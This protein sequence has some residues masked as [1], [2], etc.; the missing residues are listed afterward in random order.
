MS[1]AKIR[2]NPI[3]F[4]PQKPILSLQHHHIFRKVAQSILLL[5]T[6][7]GDRL[8]LLNGQSVKVFLLLLSHAHRFNGRRQAD[9]DG[10]KILF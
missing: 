4:L 9:S 7:L 10:F 2:L 3:I 8:Q 1:S 5:Q 6:P